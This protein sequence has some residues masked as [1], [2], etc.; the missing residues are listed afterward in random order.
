[1]STVSLIEFSEK[2]SYGLFI[3]IFPNKC[4]SCYLN[5]SSEFKFI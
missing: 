2:L 3:N 1:M 4:I 5:S